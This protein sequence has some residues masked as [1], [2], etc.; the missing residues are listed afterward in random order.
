M[1][2]QQYQLQLAGM[3]CAGC[4]K[5]I[6]KA[7]NTVTGVTSVNVNF[8]NEVAA[9]E[10]EN[11]APEALVQAI[12]DA[13]YDASVI[14][15][16]NDSTDAP[17][18]REQAQ[19]I[20]FFKFIAAAILSAPLLYSM[21]GHFSWTQGIYVPEWIM[22]PWVQMA[23]A[24]PV[25][26]IIGWQFYK[27]SYT[28]L[29]GGAANMDVLV[30]L[31]TSAA[32]FYSV[33]LAA[34]GGAEIAHQG[35]YFETSAIL[36][37]LILLG[38]WFE[39]RAKGRSS[40]AIKQLLNLQPKQAIRE[41]TDGTT[42]TVDVASLKVDDLVHIKPGQ[43]VP[44]DSKVITGE[45]AVDESMLT[46]E[47]VPVDKHEGDT[48]TGGTVNKNGFLKAQVTRLGKDSALAQIIKVV[49][50]AQNS[51]APIQRLAD[52]VSA[53]FVPV[54]LGIALVTFL[55]WAFWLEPGDYGSALEATVAV[56]VIACPCALGLATPTSI[57]AGSG[58]AAQMGVLFKQ[59]DVLEI[60]HNVTTIVLD[61]TGTITEGKPKL[62]D[63]ELELKGTDE[64]SESDLKAAIKALEQQSEHPLA[65]AIVS[66][67]DEAT[68]QLS[69][70][71]FHAHEGRGVSAQITRNNS[72]H[73]IR[74]GNSRLMQDNDITCDTWQQRKEALEQQGKTAMLISWN[75]QA[76]GI[77]AVADTVREHAQEAVSA[78]KHRG[79]KVVMI[80]GDN[81]RTADAIAK[82]VGIE[83]IFAEVLPELKAE[84]VKKLQAQGESVAMVGDG[85]NDAPALASADVGIAMGTGTDVALETA[86]IALMRADLRSLVDALYVSEKTVRNIRQNL[87]WAFAYNTLGIPVAAAGLLA[88]WLA[89]GAMALSSVS[90]VL[91]ALRLQRLP[92]KRDS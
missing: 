24:T 39:A 78:L 38:K 68:K 19:R 26:F 70:S 10:G 88:P 66:G 73:T 52:R 25:Q 49:E 2:T 83:H 55:V 90:V 15:H 91:N 80:T 43:Q 56:L 22:N 82:Q 29:R 47:S 40:A 11:L 31:G 84:H 9:V 72:Q 58:R 61:K 44:A 85:I 3:S 27:G 4:A 64:L 59:S 54:V 36:I 12:K 37:T 79:L 17:D 8:A 35:L 53:I 48:L 21:V 6:E 34:T 67:I 81:Q 62:T 16:S 65:Q 33:Y 41:L 51:K 87:F 13:G 18:Q 7:L 92:I 63:L 60:A 23:L 28:A 30:A 69:I 45:S 5:T 42:E 14:D 71:N 76:V 20:Q 75:Q 89:G 77:V 86:D 46:G 50:Q 57:M 1:A 74:L 32:Y